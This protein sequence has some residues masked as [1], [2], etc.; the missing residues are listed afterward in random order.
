ML[1]APTLAAACLALT[2]LYWL[3]WCV[4]ALYFHPASKYPGPKLAAVSEVWYVW[5]TLSG[6]EQSIMRRV[7]EKYGPV[8]RIAPNELSFDSVQS[9]RDILLPKSKGPFIKSELLYDT[10]DPAPPL[11][12]LRD[13]DA[14][15]LYR[16]RMAPS[17]SATAL[18]VQE[19]VINEYLDL[20]IK[21]LPE[22]GGENTNGLEMGEAFTWLTFDIMGRLGFG[23]GFDCIKNGKSSAWVALMSK[24]EWLPLY[25]LAGLRKRF[26]AIVAFI[27]FLLPKGAPGKIKQ[28]K[29]MSADMVRK[30]I[31]MDHIEDDWFSPVVRDIKLGKE[32]PQ[33]MES[34]TSFF[35]MAGAE[36]TATALLAAMY[37][38]KT[39]PEWL[40]KLRKEITDACGSSYVGITGSSTAALPY[41]NAFIQESIRRYG[42]VPMGLPRISPGAFIDGHYVPEGMKMSTNIWLAQHNPRSWV[43]PEE[44]K[45]ERWLGDPDWQVDGE[46]PGMIGFSLG[47]NQCLGINLAYLE[48]RLILSK[49][50]FSYDWEIIKEPKNLVDESEV[51]FL[52]K[53]PKYVVKFHPLAHQ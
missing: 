2:S 7:H 19:G 14:H 29:Q 3:S 31:Q 20:W 23:Q 8:V 1:S 33:Y 30:R 40:G 25:A 13:Y 47:R 5:R 32:S 17:F 18:R 51:Y 22:L 36:T 50:V 26:P 28:H 53:K 42:P 39:N 46:V 6:K 34:E 24:A 38:L 15:A 37:F 52:W 4:Y 49:L 45:P 11:G 44:F 12:Y 21:R 48:L 10:G 27:P 43:D 9:M 35:A 41:L 16:K